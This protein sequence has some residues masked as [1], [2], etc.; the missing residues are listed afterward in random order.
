[1]AGGPGAGKS[2]LAQQIVFS[3]ASAKAPAIYF[4]VLGE[5][6]L[7]MLR[8]VQQYGFFDKE[9][10]GGAVRFVNLSAEA[11]DHDLGS[12][13]KRMLAEIE[14]VHPATVVVDSF[15]TV[16]HASGS[17]AQLQEFV[18]RL[19]LHLTGWQATT[20]LVGEYETIESHSNPIFTIADGIIWLTQSLERNAS[21]RRM[22]VTKMRA[23]ATMPGLHTFLISSDGIRIFPRILPRT[24]LGPPPP[25]V[26]RASTG[27]ETLD[28]MMSGGIPAGG[29]ALFVGPSGSGK[30][31][32]A[33]HFIAAGAEAEE[34]G[35]IVVFEERPGEYLAQARA[36]GPELASFIKRGL[37]E[38]LYLRPLDLTVD[39][40]LA[41]VRHAVERK[42]ARRVA[43][44]SLSE[45]ELAL[46]P[47][48]RDDFRESLFRTI[49]ALTGLG[50]T[51]LMTVDIVQSFT[52]FGLSPHITEF[53]ADVLV[54]QRYVELDGKLEKVLAVVKMHTSSHDTSIRRYAIESSGVVVGEPVH[55]YGGILTGVPLVR[56]EG[57]IALPGLTRDEAALLQRLH[58]LG[59]ADARALARRTDLK[60]SALALALDRLRQLEY[61]RTTRR[62]GVTV[63]RARTS[64]R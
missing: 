23:C 53:L 29:S 62:K 21:V 31:L 52:E 11:M 50:V 14:E 42:K 34:P 32:F 63:Y 40:V 3:R 10:I 39:E 12:I 16:A 28:A 24:E 22:Q 19:A 15:R 36:F 33:R 61:V 49:S 20:F 48:Y 64:T 26:R 27:V 25:Q 17:E 57:A 37:V 58:E 47:S 4:T 60:G 7:K 9:K 51:V 59:E 43:I 38:V 13:M 8:H 6:P 2:T 35:I 1:I 5:P 55:G 56:P 30:S 45:F 54:L 18:Q 44:D 41:A 46:A